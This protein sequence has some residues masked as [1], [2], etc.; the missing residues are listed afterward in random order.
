[1]E[2]SIIKQQ[3]GLEIAVKAVSQK[4][5]IDVGVF[6][7]QR[8]GLKEYCAGS[9]RKEQLRIVYIETADLVRMGFRISCAALFVINNFL[10]TCHGASTRR[11]ANCNSDDC[12]PICAT[13]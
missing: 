1:M 3:Y 10:R 2:Y 7:P 13:H 5:E 4:N 11:V 12:M 9:R 6:V 8:F